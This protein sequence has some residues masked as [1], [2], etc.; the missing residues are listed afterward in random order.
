ML[1]RSSVK[2]FVDRLAQLP[3]SDESA[4]RVHL[5]ARAVGYRIHR[6]DFDPYWQQAMVKAVAGGVERFTEHDLRAKVITDARAQASFGAR[7]GSPVRGAALDKVP[8]PSVGLQGC[9]TVSA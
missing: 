2:E 4:S 8:A 5:F 6:L 1:I 9:A 7:Y 3:T